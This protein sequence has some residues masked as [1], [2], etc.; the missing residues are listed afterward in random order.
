MK[1]VSALTAVRAQGEA[2][3]AQGEAARAPAEA[4]SAQRQGSESTR[5]GSLRNTVATMLAT[6]LLRWGIGT[7]PS[8]A[9]A[10]STTT[11]AVVNPKHPIASVT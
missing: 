6:P 10:A 1:Y 3:K 5:R 8:D 2:V 7:T 11:A 9:T 4:V